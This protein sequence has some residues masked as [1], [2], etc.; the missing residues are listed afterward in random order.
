MILLLPLGLTQDPHFSQFYA[1]RVYLNPAFTGLDSDFAFNLNYRDQWF[2]IPDA[3]LTPDSYRTFNLA[4]EVRI[5]ENIGLAAS[6][7]YDAAGDA[8]FE[9]IGFSTAFNGILE[10]DKKKET[11]IS[12]GVQV[13]FLQQRLT[14]N[15]LIYSNQIDP[16]L[17]VIGTPSIISTRSKFL[18]NLNVGGLYRGR[19]KKNFLKWKINIGFEAGFQLSNITEPSF[20]L[21]EAGREFELPLKLTVHGRLNLKKR[22]KV[23]SRRYRFYN[24]SDAW[25]IMGSWEHQAS[26]D[27]IRAGF[28]W[29]SDASYINSYFQ[30]NPNTYLSSTSPSIQGIFD[31][32][33]T[34]V[35]SYGVDVKSVFD[36]GHFYNTKR[37]RDALVIGLSYDINFSGLNSGTNLGVIEINMKMTFGYDKVGCPE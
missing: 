9:T 25:G 31:N 28:F 27:L 24:T 21:R 13:G 17:G 4:G 11:S 32:T 16:V 36:K 20:T 33:S 37:S 5:I 10:L 2:G 15:H 3:T 30:F 34:L 35:L 12:L 7:L 19:L 23:G 22:P 26:F 1:N 6:V 18:P 14:S 29:V 8:P